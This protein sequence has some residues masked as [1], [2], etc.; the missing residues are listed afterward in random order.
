MSINSSALEAVLAASVNHPF[1]VQVR[2][3]E[4]CATT[5]Q[6]TLCSRCTHHND[7]RAATKAT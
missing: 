5:A 1:V 4:A 7:A 3:Q 6:A 2:W